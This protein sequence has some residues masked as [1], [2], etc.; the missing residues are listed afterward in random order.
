MKK[1]Y[2]KYDPEFRFEKSVECLHVYIPT[3]I[4]YIDHTF[5]HTVSDEIN[6]DMWRLSIAFMC[7]DDLENAVSITNSGEWDMAIRLVDRPDFIGGFAHGD[8][9]L[10]DVKFIVDG[11]E[12]APT[13]FTDATEFETMTVIEN[14]IGFDPLDSKTA[15]F[16]HHKEITFSKE[17]VRV[18]QNVKW[19][20]D[21]DFSHAY[22]AMMPPAKQYTDSFYTNITEPQDISVP[23]HHEL[24]GVTSMTVFGKESGLYFTMTVNEYD[25]YGKPHMSIRDNGGGPYNKMYL[26]LALNESVKKA[27]DAGA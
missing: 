16:E 18:D 7:D 22:F 9:R 17:G 21:Y 23:P 13:S 2:I 12:A 8:E 10:T 20:G 4:G 1:L 5:G 3:E 15:V 14:S 25:L 19:L 6:A 24:D 27:A 11:V 26:S